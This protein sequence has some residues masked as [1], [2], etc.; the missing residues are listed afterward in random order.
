VLLGCRMAQYARY[1]KY[2]DRLG[3]VILIGIGIKIL[4]EH[5]Y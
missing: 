2:L 1:R 5:L 3:A 4:I